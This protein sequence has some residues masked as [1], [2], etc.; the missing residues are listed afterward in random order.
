[1]QLGHETLRRFPEEQL[2]EEPTS[3]SLKNTFNDKIIDLHQ[4]PLLSAVVISKS[5]AITP[6]IL[7]S[8]PARLNHLTLN[9]VSVEETED[10]RW[11][12]W[13]ALTRSA[14]VRGPI[15]R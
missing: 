11:E 7:S 5:P 4:V 15:A 6:S 9:A 8:T 1:M 2:E 10:G 3:G 14:G 13:I 12:I